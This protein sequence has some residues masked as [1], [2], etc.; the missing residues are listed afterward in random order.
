MQVRVHL[1]IGFPTAEHEY[2]LEVDDE[3]SDEELQQACEEWA[4]DHIEYYWEKVD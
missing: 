4:N 3:A 1:S 2:V